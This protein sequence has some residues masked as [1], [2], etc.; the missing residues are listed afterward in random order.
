MAKCASGS[1]HTICVSD[2]G[3]VY[4]F[5]CN[6]SGQLGLEQSCVHRRT[7]IPTQNP[8]LQKITQVSCGLDFTVCIDEE[9]SIWSFGDNDYGQLGLGNYI[10]FHRIPQK[11][12]NIPPVQ[13]I[14]CGYMH[15]LILCTDSNLWSVGNN[16]LGQLCLG[17]TS[18]KSKPHQSPYSNIS[19]ISAG[20][21]FSMFQ[22][23]DGEIYGCGDNEFGQLGFTNKR[24]Q[25]DV[26]LI[27]NHPLDILELCCGSYHSLLLDSLGI[28]Y[29]A[30]MIKY[31]SLGHGHN[32]PKKKFKQ[33]E[34]IPNIPPIQKI[35][36]SW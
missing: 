23:M 22:N 10:E 25:F 16:T 15:L 33:W 12:E 8:H 29:A 11:V 36:C 26:I 17:E 32:D 14:S 2:D 24:F 6:E 28:V 27:P 9:G 19:K 13:S 7:A 18:S 34:K 20:C 35:S 31:G 1:R 5:G 3:I 30:G 21:E 4:A